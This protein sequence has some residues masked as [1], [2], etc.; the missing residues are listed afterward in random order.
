MRVS[1]V[2]DD[3]FSPVQAANTKT[4]KALPNLMAAFTSNLRTKLR[5]DAPRRCLRV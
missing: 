4:I 2:E 1:D 3:V 5:D